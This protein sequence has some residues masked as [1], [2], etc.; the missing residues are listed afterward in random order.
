MRQF[1]IYMIEIHSIVTSAATG[2]AHNIAHNTAYYI[3]F[4]VFP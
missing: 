3:V 1:M 2:I 4:D